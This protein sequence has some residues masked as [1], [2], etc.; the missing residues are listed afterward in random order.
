MLLEDIGGAI[1]R[2]G[3]AIAVAKQPVLGLSVAGD[4]QALQG[5]GRV[6]PQ[7]TEPLLAAFAK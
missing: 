5:R 3:L 2:Q 1:A 4:E 6:A 7:G